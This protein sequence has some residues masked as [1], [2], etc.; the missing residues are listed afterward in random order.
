M[1][2]SPSRPFRWPGG[3]PPEVKPDFN[4]D[5]TFEEVSEAAKGWLLFV[6]VPLSKS[7]YLPIF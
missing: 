3:I 4:S 1:D 7:R 2:D 5:W 6:T